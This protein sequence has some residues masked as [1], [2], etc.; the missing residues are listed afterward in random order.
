[1]YV[2]EYDRAADRQNPGYNI[3]RHA[4]VT[5]SLYQFARAGHDEV[6]DTADAGLAEMLDQRGPGRRRHR[7]RRQ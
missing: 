6:L 7:L 4:G 2:Y 1:M 5:M 3:V